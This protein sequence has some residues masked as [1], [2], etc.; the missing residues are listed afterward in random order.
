MTDIIDS[1]DAAPTTDAPSEDGRASS[2][3][4][5]RSGGLNTKL[6]P[7][8]KQIAAGLGIKTGGMKKADLVGAIKAAQAGGQGGQAAQAAQGSDKAA[9]KNGAAREEKRPEARQESR[10]ESR[11]ESRPESRGGTRIGCGGARTAPEVFVWLSQRSIRRSTE[12]LRT[13]RLLLRS[14]SPTSLPSTAPRASTTR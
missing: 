14:S 2:G 5:A 9:E 1:H 12:Q 7:E 3:S 10:R 6:M 11:Q 8:L 13:R 4:R